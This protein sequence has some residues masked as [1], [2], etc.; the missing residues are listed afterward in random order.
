VDNFDKIEKYLNHELG[1]NEKRD[2]ESL[3]AF[4]SELKSSLQ[5]HKMARMAIDN[6][7]AS[8][9]R[10][11]MKSWSSVGPSSSGKVRKFGYKIVSLAAC[12]FA[13]YAG[14]HFYAVYNYSNATLGNKYAYIS[15]GQTRS[16]ESSELSPLSKA[17]EEINS[18]PQLAL[19]SLEA[20][21]IQPSSTNESKEKIEWN[22]IICHLKLNQADKASSLLQAIIKNT[23]HPYNKRAQKLYADLN[24]F[25]R[26]L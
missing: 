20:L 13:I 25:W 9:L 10:N 1:E 7:I 3:L 26:S 14:L 21:Y 2:F 24:S 22:I 8:Q 4:D 18:N 23:E 5:N 17:I 15:N 16:S 11:D 19:Q 6:S 12:L